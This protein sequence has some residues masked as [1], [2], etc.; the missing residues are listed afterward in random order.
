[1]VSQ[2]AGLTVSKETTKKWEKEQKREQRYLNTMISRREAMELVQ[3]AMTQAD[4]RMRMLF[5][6]VNA[7][8]S[9][10]KD[11]GLITEQE[12]N[13]YSRP[14]I[15]QMYGLSEEE[16]DK[17]EQERKAQ[18]ETF[19]KATDPTIGKPVEEGIKDGN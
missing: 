12:L 2:S 11:K 8:M 1:M 15:S 17:M 5:I 16:I 6:S 4:E 13:E 9:G 7:I 14:F 18:Q 10:L 3:G 19:E